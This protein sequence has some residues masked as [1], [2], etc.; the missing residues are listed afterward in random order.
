MAS[1]PLRKNPFALF[2]AAVTLAVALSLWFIQSPVFARMFKEKAAHYMPKDL[3]IEADFSEFAIRLFPPA[4]SMRDPKITLRE[5]NVLKL[6]AGSSLVAERM[7]LVF[8]PF[9][10]LSGEI[11]VHEVAVV[12]G[13]LQL[14]LP[15]GSARERKSEP[16]KG[17]AKPSVKLAVHWDELFQIR[18]EAVS[19]QDTQLR[20]RWEGT[21]DTFGLQA[22]ALRVG[23]WS[24]EGGLGYEASI[25]VGDLQGT[26]LEEAQIVKRLRQLKGLARVNETGI[27]IENLSISADGFQASATGKIL[28][29]VLSPRNLMLDAEVNATGDLA[30]AAG[31]IDPEAPPPLAGTAVFNGRVRGNLDRPLETLW[32][33]GSVE[34]Q[35]PR[36]ALWHADR[37]VAKGGWKAA[38]DGGEVTLAQALIEEAPAPRAPGTPARGG[39]VEIGSTRINLAELKSPTAAAAV[40]A[41]LKLTDAHVQWL[42]PMAMK[43][44]FALDFRASGAINAKFSKVRGPRKW[45]LEAETDLQVGPFQ[46]DN[47]RVNKRKPVKRV[48]R[49][50]ALSLSGPVTIDGTAVRPAGAV[51]R[52]PK[53]AL[54][55]G[56]KI[57]FKTGWDL[58]GSGPTDLADL[59]EVAETPIRGAGNLGIRVHGPSSR[60]FIDIDV[61]VRDAAYLNL[62]LGDLKGRI[63]WD[64]DPSLLFFRHVQAS[65][66]RTSYVVDG[67]LDLDQN[68]SVALN[69]R[70]AEGDVNDLIG[71]FDFLVKDVWW[72]PKTLSGPFIGELAVTGGLD[73]AKL[74]VLG[75]LAG[76]G[77]DYLGER[78]DSAQLAGGYDR[79]K[80][81]VSDARITKHG[82]TI[83]GRIVSEPDGR[84]DWDFHTR[85]FSLT[86]IDHVAQL[87]V[88]FR[89]RLAIDTTGKGKVGAIVSNTTVSVTDLSV[90]GAALPP[91]QLQMR[92]ERG[93]I[94]VKGE[95]LGGQGKLDVSYDGETGGSSTIVA[96]AR[97]FDFSPILLLLNPKSVPDGSVT[98]LVSGATN[99]QFR[100]GAIE[101][102]SG[103]FEV[104][105]YVLAKSGARFSLGRPVSVRVTDGSFDLPSLALVGGGRGSSA[106]ASLELHSRKAQLEGSVT[107]QI[108][109][110]ML[111]FFTSTITQAS[112]MANLDFAIAGTFKE[113][114]LQGRAL[115]DGITLRV[116]ALD[117]PFENL[118]GSLLV[119][120][121]VLSFRGIDADLAGGRVTAEGNIVLFPDRWPE[122]GIR[123][124]LLGPKIKVYPFQFAKVRGNLEVKGAQLPYAV[125]GTVFVDSAVSREK[126]F[127]QRSGQ[128][129]KAALYTPPPSRRRVSDYP[130]FKLNIDA[131]SDGG[132]LIQNELV[133]A[134]VKGQ[135]TIVNTIEAPRILGSAELVQGRL[136]FKDRTFQIQS[137]NA[138]FDSPTVIN[139]RFSLTA[140]A[141]VSNVKIN[142]YAAGRIEDQWKIELSSNPPMPESEIISL[143]ALG[144]TSTD[145]RKLSSSDRTV[146]EQGE[147]ASLI[148]HSLDF[149]REVES[150]TGLRFQFDETVNSQQGTSIF[151]PSSQSESS[152]AP[153]IVL[154]R[155][156]TKDVDVS[157]GSTVGVGTGSQKEVSAEVKVTP[158]LSVIGVYD[159]YEITDSNT[160]GSTKQTS[161]GLDL[162]LQK[163][164]K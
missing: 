49:I 138:V 120:Q 137:A 146:V 47:Q 33:Q 26:L 62:G 79:G 108:D 71:I 52:M 131:R 17:A 92:S 1:R 69:V 164:F 67:K 27:Q 60:V 84:F 23:Q 22:K 54:K 36:Y 38:P 126:V 151:R 86:D 13:D 19:L 104:S 150:K 155:Q 39:R 74:Q 66:N 114:A 58:Y 15:K 157:Y 56:G 88:P 132:I 80:Y 37:V 5:R 109:L 102:A 77:W 153:K 57:D 110:S 152:A 111:E 16:P 117:S 6:P 48:L 73:L 149:N 106:E 123:A 127:Q 124:N 41:S 53:T 76:R 105:E 3:G 96:E 95:A 4:I 29:N 55:I 160:N 107:G 143:L 61:D 18:A 161:Y 12:K 135:L 72:F 119:K 103:T 34:V 148:L 100:S 147:A 142:L 51:L 59:S 65:R 134:E 68:D 40:Q 129:L 28:G 101:R 10:M 21:S 113:L 31:F 14:V 122:L 43:D 91:S 7:D 85:G 125:N 140:N 87:D 154:K 130:K 93:R 81:L 35:S 50:P 64:D 128:G 2:M 116:S 24:G 70:F 159:T 158:G 115:Y 97:R 112:G 139:P 32:A 162:K 121:N 90:R 44:V 8:R 98:G 136:V 163:R 145:A 25:E 30:E 46:L 156:I 75:K 9:Q 82:G 99:L 94:D 78:L 118:R 83:Q 133:D 63:T 89:G 11:R 141:E 45:L 144:I 42:A 20:I